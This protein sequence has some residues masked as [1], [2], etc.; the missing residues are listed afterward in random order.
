MEEIEL[1]P[2]PPPK[3]QTVAETQAPDV[4]LLPPPPPKKKSQD[5]SVSTQ[6]AKQDGTP[7][8]LPTTLDASGVMSALDKGTGGAIKPNTI[9]SYR[10]KQAELQKAYGM[11]ND[12]YANKHIGGNVQSDEIEDAAL[13]DKTRAAD[14]NEAI[15]LITAVRNNP[16]TSKISDKITDNEQYLKSVATNP[17]IQALD[18]LNKQYQSAVQSGD[19]QTAEQI[20]AQIDQT[21]SQPFVNSDPQAVQDE[22]NRWAQ[23]NA[24]DTTVPSAVEGMQKASIAK[25]LADFNAKHGITDKT[26]VGDIYGQSTQKGQ[27][28]AQDRQN[29]GSLYSA[30]NHAI[31]DVRRKAGFDVTKDENGN[32]AH[33][34]GAKESFLNGINETATGVANGV[35]SLAMSDDEKIKAINDDI[36]R[37]QALYPTKPETPAGELAQ[38]AGSVLPYMVQGAV[39]PES[40]VA[41]AIMSGATFGADA[42]WSSLVEAYQEQKQNDP[43]ISNQ[44]A[45]D[46]AKKQS[47]FDAAKGAI[48]GAGLP[49]GGVAGEG[50]AKKAL[51]K[52]A[53]NVL[54]KYAS[55]VGVDASLFGGSRYA[56][57]LYAN[58]NGAKRDLSSGVGDQ[59]KMAVL[60]GT[61]HTLRDEMPQ[62]VKDVYDAG[63]AKI[64]PDIDISLNE[65]VNSG[66]MTQ[67]QANKV[68]VPTLQA[69]EVLD[70][71]PQNIGVVKDQQ[72]M[73]LMREKMGLIEQKKQLDKSF[74][75]P[76]DKKIGAIDDEIKSIMA[77]RGNEETKA[78][79]IARIAEDVKASDVKDEDLLH[80]GEHK[81]E[82]DNLVAKPETESV[83]TPVQDVN[84]KTDSGQ[85]N[86]SYGNEVEVNGN[87]IK[88]PKTGLII[89]DINLNEGVN[90]GKGK[91]QEL[92][93]KALDEHGRIYSTSPISEDALNAQNALEKKGLVKITNEEHGGVDFRVI[94]KT[95]PV[96]EAIEPVQEKEELRDVVGDSARDIGISH[97]YG[98]FLL[99]E[100]EKR[101]QDAGWKDSESLRVGLEKQFN[102]TLKDRGEQRAISNLEDSYMAQLPKD[103]RGAEARNAILKKFEKSQTSVLSNRVPTQE[104]SEPVQEKN[105][106][107]SNQPNYDNMSLDE[108]RALKKEKYS[109]PDIESAMSDDEK[110]LTKAIAKKFSELNQEIA[111]RRKNKANQE[112]SE[113]S[114]QETREPVQESGER[115]YKLNSRISKDSKA[116]AIAVTNPDFNAIEELFYVDH[117][118][119]KSLK[120]GVE[121]EGDGWL[122]IP[123][124]GSDSKYLYR[125]ETKEAVIIKSGKGGRMP[126]IIKD[127]IESNPKTK[128]VSEPE[129][130]KSTPSK[131]TPRQA[132]INGLLDMQDAYNKMSDGARGKSSADGQRLRG[133]I[134]DKVAELGLTMRE[135]GKAITVRSAIDRPVKRNMSAEGN[136]GI[137]EEHTPLTSR[138]E[139]VKS[140]FELL[141][142]MGAHSFPEIYGAD[143]KRMSP[144]QIETAVKD[145]KEG[146]PTNG[147]EI[148]LN[149]L[150]DAHHSGNID[151]I[152]LNSRETVS[153]PMKD[154]LDVQREAYHGSDEHINKI[155]TLAED[156][157]DSL[158]EE[159]KTEL[160]N[161]QEQARLGQADQAGQ[162]GAVSEESANTETQSDIGQKDAPAQGGQEPPTTTESETGVKEPQSYTSLKN[163]RV[164]AEREARG[165]SPAIQEARK[166]FGKSWDEAMA[167]LD[168]NPNA[169]NELINGLGEIKGLKEKPRPLSD[170]ENAMLLHRQVELQ[171]DYAKQAEAV[172]KAAETGD[173]S[174]L[175]EAKARL[176][177][178][179]DALQEIY[180]IGKRAGTEN[181]RGLSIRRMLAKEDFSLASMETKKRAANDGKPLTPE[182]KAHIEALHERINETQKAFEDYVANAEKKRAEE[183]ANE[184]LKQQRRAR[185]RVD[186]EKILSQRTKI[187]SDI[188]DKG[189]AILA[190]VAEK[191]G[192]IKNLDAPDSES[193]TTLLKE[194]APDIADLAKNYAQEGVIN[195]NEIV[196]KIHDE[197]GDALGLSKRNIRDAISGYGIEK[198]KSTRSE[199][200]KELDRLK[201]EA[202]KLSRAEDIKSGAIDDP[203]LK[204]YK[205]RTANRIKEVEEKLKN[206][207]FAKKE[208]RPIG[209]DKEG[210]ALKAEYE[211]AKQEFELGL[212][213]DRLKNRSG[214]EKTLDAIVKWGRTA[215]LSSPITLA[216][217][218]S[219]AI[220]RMTTTPLE[221]VV[222]GGIS[223]L[224]PNIAKQAL[225]EGGFNSKAEA[226]AIT[227]GIMN[228]IRASKDILN[229]KKGGKS[230]LEV[231]FG[232]KRLPPAAID[233]FGHLHSALKAPAKE[234]E[235]ERSLQKRLDASIRNG[236]D[237]TD[238]LV[239]ASIL[240]L[241]YKDA[242]RAIFMQDNLISSANSALI[243][244]LENNKSHPKSGKFAASVLQELMPFVKVPTNVIGETFT[245]AGGLP[246][247]V[248]D[249]VRVR[250][251]AKLKAIG[252]ERLASVLHEGMGDLKPDEADMILRT[253]KK[254]SIGA[255]FLL[256]G[257][258]NPTKVGG[259]NSK[260]K[261]NESEVEEGELKVGDV[262]IPKFML[263]NP[264]METL[265]LGATIRQVKDHYVDNEDKYPILEGTWAAAMGLV[266]QTPMIDQ[267][268]RLD[269]LA[270]HPVDYAGEFTKGATIPALVDFI[271]RY[272]DVDENGN[273]IKRKPDGFVEHLESAIPFLRQRV[274]NN[275][276][277]ENTPEQTQEMQT[278][279]LN[280]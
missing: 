250:A 84:I 241:A 127:F 130:I 197:I 11:E 42:K 196:D 132:E 14:E 54:E 82:I 78:E 157:F 30:S 186:K 85:I 194:I 24:P 117:T 25:R 23:R 247:G 182:V 245:Y 261:E 153:I 20:K 274:G 71:M 238:P 88:L 135:N 60:F 43:N 168:E 280:K 90:K 263:H 98:K 253:L 92:Y 1:L 234:A 44:D 218:T 217:L 19:A 164:D 272:T 101:M 179:S 49:F 34:M 106:V 145:V 275:K 151:M 56:S 68:I 150:E 180:D 83:E 96:Q 122:S 12:M 202:R 134:K 156:W 201:A 219:A 46:A 139:D 57:N 70:K 109:N 215:K 278:I 4:D 187:V 161:G 105:E 155:H 205:N 121:D 17:S 267:A 171:N 95:T 53:L 138:G 87:K 200:Q 159:Q 79:R 80:Y 35:A 31:A 21:S 48:V 246:K 115:E 3:K 7:S 10:Q 133:Q 230:N 62:H 269:K 2:P 242:N 262:A 270:K 136:K 244:Y 256:L 29:L 162:G 55:K 149:T 28:L 189:A 181:A 166:A 206:G 184:E 131:I 124:I 273:R 191:T 45:L 239:Q 257:Y 51:S 58:S 183:D 113:T 237:V 268:G 66:K 140:T 255:A 125:P 97:P 26:T 260:K 13:Q 65:A 204:A 118:T 258:F 266:S 146:R 160:L 64:F 225:R 229:I 190:R 195:L 123:I 222:G 271:A 213:K 249:V 81:D 32:E 236:V 152:D 220:I 103:V 108:L 107:V 61:L 192:A 259:Y 8:A 193:L 212:E 38:T 188:K 172:I 252:A 251:S 173:E 112:L 175:A 248:A 227:T 39:L 216:K 37:K 76:I 9:E 52:G 144:R 223:K 163:K 33:L 129:T 177:G 170:V 226:K 209:L 104:A 74:H 15:K 59:V 214:Y 72:L 67:E 264:L 198:E 142:D 40:A 5:T 75:E 203:K 86:G 254:G 232:E 41:Q 276:A 147:A 18:K 210:L 169:T 158:P 207:D 167:I 16:L 243:R 119:K 36:A 120:K 199:L 27:E 114:E 99:D 265:Q 277:D 22:Y 6:P 100:I 211:R 233:F 221:E 93:M 47:N 174:A 137:A 116:T 240:T 148:L 279:E 69:K 91:G 176:A 208:R 77:G 102:E 63:M 231:L 110:A 89:S 94:E 154:Y 178:T 235:F 126:Y 50:L 165:L 128:S 141:S 143:G 111:D 73:P 185:T 228:G 224:I